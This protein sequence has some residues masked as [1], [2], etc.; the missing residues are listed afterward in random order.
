MKFVNNPALLQRFQ[1]LTGGS[2]IRQQRNRGGGAGT[3]EAVS[4]GAAGVAVAD[5]DGLEDVPEA[6]VE[7]AEP[8]AGG[9]PGEAPHEELGVGG[10]PEGRGRQVQP[11]AGAGR[12]RRPGRRPRVV[13]VQSH[14]EGASGSAGFL[15]AGRRGSSL[16]AIP[17]RLGGGERGLGRRRWGESGAEWEKKSGG[18]EGKGGCD[19]GGGGVLASGW[20]PTATGTHNSHR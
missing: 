15:G 11:R 12:R 18:D 3:D 2:R 7:A 5:D 9:L 19:W 6:L 20:R 4:F 17:V 13:L 8:L 16:A 14:A 1:R 10:V